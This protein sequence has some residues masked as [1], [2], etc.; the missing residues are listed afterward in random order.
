LNLQLKPDDRVIEK[1]WERE[2]RE[3]TEDA[4]QAMKIRLDGKDGKETPTAGAE[5]EEEA[6]VEDSVS[7]S[8]LQFHLRNNVIFF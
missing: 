7:F 5:E 4:L 8:L 1:N 6:L 3:A 2:L